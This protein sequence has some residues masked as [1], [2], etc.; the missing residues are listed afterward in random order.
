MWSGEG[1]R[2]YRQSIRFEDAFAA[3]PAVTV[4]LS[5]WDISNSANARADISAVE[6]DTEGFVVQFRTW[7]DTRVARI[8]ASWL[9]IGPVADDD[10][11]D[12]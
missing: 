4:G 1:P 12:V 11:W 7:G 8:R 10:L 3:P 5:M 2:E 9:A 6:I